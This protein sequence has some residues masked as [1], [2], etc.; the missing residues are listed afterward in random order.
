MICCPCP[1]SPSVKICIISS[2]IHN[3]VSVC[4]LKFPKNSK[5][6]PNEFQTNS[7]RIPKEF[8]KEFPKN[9]QKIPKEFPGNSERIP[10]KFQKNSQRIP[11]EYP[12]ISQKF[13]K[14]LI[15]IPKI[16]WLAPICRNPFRACFSSFYGELSI[17]PFV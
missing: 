17:S 15:K 3:F 4:I 7:K 10:R 13:S 2:H 9:F 12:K 1:V 11:K 16:F 6:I 14:I 5:R 8:P